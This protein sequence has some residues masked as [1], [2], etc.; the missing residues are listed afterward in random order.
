[1]V[2]EDTANILV[3]LDDCRPEV[4]ISLHDDEVG[5]LAYILKKFLLAANQ[6]RRGPA[7]FE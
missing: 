2:L 1:M 5:G 4:L 3:S 7:E 6:V